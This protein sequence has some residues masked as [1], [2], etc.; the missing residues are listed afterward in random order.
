MFATQNCAFFCAL[1]FKVLA[2]LYGELL[3]LERVG[4]ETQFFDAGGHSLLA[5]RL[6][7]S[8]RTTFGVEYSLK[9]FFEDPILSTVASNIKVAIAAVGSGQVSDHQQQA[10]RPRQAVPGKVCLGRL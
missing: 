1:F 2:A 4:M 9:Q 8:I 5:V 7:S 6:L 3:G 10:I